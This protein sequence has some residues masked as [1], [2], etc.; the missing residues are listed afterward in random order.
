VLV[1]ALQIFAE[2]PRALFEL[3]LGGIQISQQSLDGHILPAGPFL[4]P[5]IASAFHAV[6]LI[7][8]NPK[9]LRDL[10]LSLIPGLSHL[11]RSPLKVTSKRLQQEIMI[12]ESIN[13]LAQPIPQ[14]GIGPLTMQHRM[15]QML[16]IK[17]AFRADQPM[18]AVQAHIVEG[19]VVQ[20]AGPGLAF[21]R[22][23]R[24]GGVRGEG[25]GGLG[26]VQDWARVGVGY[27]EA[28]EVLVLGL[29]VRVGLAEALAG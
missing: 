17:R 7:P 24:E 28:C 5:C 6:K 13:P 11:L 2:H 25:A 10:I 23:L 4:Q 15:S 9:L 20:R 22:G 12:A 29:R 21:A 27:V 1:L 18:R 16:A 14:Q 19:L 3:S 8:D 26:V